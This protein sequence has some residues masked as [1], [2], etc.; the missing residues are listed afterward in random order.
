MKGN[1]QNGSSWQRRQQQQV[2]PSHLSAE[3][4]EGKLRTGELLQGVLRVN[5]Q[6][7]KQAFVTVNGICRDVYIDG[8]LARN[9]AVHGD[10]VAVRLCEW[11]PTSSTLSSSSC[12]PPSSSALTSQSQEYND[13]QISLW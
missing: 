11:A 12:P 13:V 7:K 8:E 2:Y 1:N 10:V 5:V 4:V 9:R 6:N 3:D